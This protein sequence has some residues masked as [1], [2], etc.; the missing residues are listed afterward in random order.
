MTEGVS[1]QYKNFA[2][3]FAGQVLEAVADRNPNPIYEVLDQYA[4]SSG[5]LSHA[6]LA[7]LGIWRTFFKSDVES[8]LWLGYVLSVKQGYEKILAYFFIAAQQRPFSA[9]EGGDRP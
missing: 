4:D 2:A 8:F 1:E 6:D 9:M 5:K 3:L 7:L